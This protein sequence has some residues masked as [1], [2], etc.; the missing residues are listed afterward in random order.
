MP[1]I[2]SYLITEHAVFSALFDEIEQVLAEAQT[3]GEVNRLA[4]LVES[5]LN[6]HGHIEADLAFSALDHRLAEEGHLNQLHQDHDEIDDHLLRA[7]TSQDFA[8]AVRLLR[9]AI[10]T[11]R[12]HFRREEHTVFPLF[13]EIFHPE[14][15]EVLGNTTLQ[16]YLTA[17][18]AAGENQPGR[19]A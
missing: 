2:T 15:L 11:S 13:E 10:K 8:E 12:I 1:S 17:G 19:R 4:R 6:R 16:S 14:S 3:V 9:K 5:V 18:R 7:R